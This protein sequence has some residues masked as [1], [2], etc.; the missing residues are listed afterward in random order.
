LFGDILD[1]M[2]APLLFVWPVS[3]A[4]THYFANNVAA[5]PYDQSLREQV[6]AI[7]RQVKV[8]NGRVQVALPNSARAILRSDEV[9]QVYFRVVQR[10]GKHLAGDSE[11]PLAED[12]LTQPDEPGEVF[13]RDA[14]INGQELRIAYQYIADPS[15]PRD[16][17][18]LVEVGETRE[19]RGQLANRI[20][21][22]VILP[23]FVIIPLAVILVWFGLSQGLKPLT[24]LRDKI[25]AR[26][27]GDV[28]EIS[29]RGVPDEMVPLIEAFNALIERT[30]KNMQAQQRFIADAAHQLRTPLAG[31]KMQAQ[32]ALRETDPAALHHALNNVASGVDRSNRLV[33][34]ML[35]LAR[36]EAL[37]RQ[38]FVAVDLEALVRQLSEDWF[39]RAVDRQIDFG[40]EAEGEA[41]TLGNEFLLRE[42]ISNLIDNALRYTPAGGRVTARVL[43]LGDFVIV[44]VE[45]TGIGISE[46]DTELVFEPFYRVDDSH[47][48][49]SGLGLAIVRQIAELHRANVSLRPNIKE[50][51]SV[52]RVV[53]PAFQEGRAPGPDEHD[54]DTLVESLE[55]PPVPT[56]FV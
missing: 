28:S 21:A 31:L 50:R 7:A 46:A 5:F 35:A 4:V 32:L 3:I 18:V 24:R 6:S 10:N 44:E 38:S 53:F 29:T 2:L 26:R 36:A 49:G 9:D 27:P 33:T 37:D 40:Y 20:V 56:G 22:S 43:P 45:D 51:G 14:E 23:Q 42:L 13:F 11:L 52:A 39:D 8:E 15:L 30:R 47:S 16:R 19:K 54:G 48:E 41:R 55:H 12:V 34:Q 1:W 17:W 25:E